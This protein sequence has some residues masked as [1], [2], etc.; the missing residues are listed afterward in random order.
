MSQYLEASPLLA[1]GLFA[2]LVGLSIP[3]VLF[4]LFSVVNV[5][6]VIAGFIILEGRVNSYY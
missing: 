4:V 6:F 1:C 2:I 5:A 3:I